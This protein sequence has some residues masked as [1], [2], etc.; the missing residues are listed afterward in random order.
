MIATVLQMSKKNQ[1]P[2]FLKTSVWLFPRVVIGAK[3]ARV[4]GTQTFQTFA[5]YSLT[6]RFR[7]RLNHNEAAHPQR[8][9]E[10]EETSFHYRVIC[11]TCFSKSSDLRSSSRPSTPDGD[12]FHHL[13]AQISKIVRRGRC[14]L[15]AWLIPGIKLHDMK[16][17]KQ[18]CLV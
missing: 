9:F 6:R 18:S 15:I 12:F 2:L 17:T 7:R 1:F 8:Q 14:I 5:L 11:M 4:G 16:D 13:P 10:S 3:Q